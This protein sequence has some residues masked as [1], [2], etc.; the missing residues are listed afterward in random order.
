M[1]LNSSVF[2]SRGIDWFTTT[3]TDKKTALLVLLRAERLMARENRAG[4]F[5]KPWRMSGYAG[6][7]CGRIEYGTRNDGAIARLSSDL[8][9]SEWW[10]FWQITGRCS[11]IDLQATLRHVD[12]PNV[13]LRKM[14]RMVKRFYRDRNDGPE[15]RE[16]QTHRGGYTLYIGKRTSSLFFRGYNKA[17]QSGL[18]DYEGCARLELEVKG[19]LCGPV[20]NCLQSYETIAQ[21]VC[22]ILTKFMTDR[23]MAPISAKVIPTS[24]YEVSPRVT[25][26]LKSLQWLDA[27]VKPS[28]LKLVEMGLLEEVCESLGLSKFVEPRAVVHDNL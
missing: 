25:D 10:D 26:C 9:D 13:P 2:V 8:A 21:G 18:S 22:G 11:R 23:G 6:W 28:V 20:I 15:I 19:C 1:W 5:I 12:Q 27:G 14:A 3:A 7:R 4:G 16:V 17:A 24:L